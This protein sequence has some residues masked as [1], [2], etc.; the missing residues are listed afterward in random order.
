MFQS[1]SGFHTEI[2]ASPDAQLKKL[3]SQTGSQFNN[4]SCWLKKYMY[5]H[6]FIYVS[7]CFSGSGKS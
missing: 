4:F 6:I 2:T 3:A 7:I 1:E 5:I